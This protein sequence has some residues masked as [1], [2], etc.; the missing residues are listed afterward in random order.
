ME[1]QTPDD[2]CEARDV[3]ISATISDSDTTIFY[4]LI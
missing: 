1:I 4:K 3:T 2:I